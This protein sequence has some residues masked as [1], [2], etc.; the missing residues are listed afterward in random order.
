MGK[1]SNWNS[2]WVAPIFIVLAVLIIWLALYYLPLSDW[3]LTFDTGT[4]WILMPWLL[5]FGL[6]MYTL[7]KL[8]FKK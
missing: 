2:D 8:V 5:M 3:G 4:L 6:A 7:K 1:K